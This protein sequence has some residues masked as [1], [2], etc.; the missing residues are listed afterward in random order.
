MKTRIICLAPGR[1]APGMT[2]A[3]PAT[4]HEG[5]VLLAADTVLDTA[6]LDRLSRRGVEAISVLLLDTRDADTI[7][8]ELQSAETR[9]AA[10]FRGSGSSARDELH[11]VILAYRQECAR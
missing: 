9:I 11:A 7:E 2:L 5:R 1:V 10:I 4:D 6:T 8:R 3:T